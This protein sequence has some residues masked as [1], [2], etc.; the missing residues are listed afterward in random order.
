MA[1]YLE[2]PADGA[3]PLLYAAPSGLTPSGSASA[4]NGAGG[5]PSTVS[6]SSISSLASAGQPSSTPGRT[7]CQHCSAA[8]L[9]V[10]SV[11]AIALVYSMMQMTFA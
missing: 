11:T 6:S 3:A 7:A 8:F 4:I 5:I 1:V 2:R 10:G 9:Q